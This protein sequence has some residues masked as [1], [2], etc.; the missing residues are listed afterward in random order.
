M[1]YSTLL[2]DWIDRDGLNCLKIKLR[3]DNPDW[4]YKRLVAIGEIAQE[5]NVD[6]FTTDFNC[7]KSDP[8]YVNDILI[9]QV[10]TSILER[11][12]R[13]S[14]RRAALSHDLEANQIDAHSVSARKPLFMDE[15]AHDLKLI[16]SG[17]KLGWTGVARRPARPK[18]SPVEPL[19]PKPTA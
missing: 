10:L 11:I 8:E 19:L 14:L 16:R 4:D 18:P 9:D 2:S 6:W 1:A 7:A 5:K 3:G 17:R 15:S 12:K 13:L